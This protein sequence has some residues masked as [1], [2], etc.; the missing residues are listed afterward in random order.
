MANPDLFYEV[1]LS[2]AKNAVWIHSSCGSTVGRFGRMGIDL[3]TTVAEQLAG[4]PEC[5]YCTHGKPTTEDWAKFR[6]LAMEYWGV[7][8]PLD[9]FDPV[10]LA[11]NSAQ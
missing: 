8:V 6:Q 10:L 9:A 7:D 4:A 11:S 3:H 1:Q 5:R 2:P